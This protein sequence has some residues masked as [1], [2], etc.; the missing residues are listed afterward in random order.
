MSG[1]F[2]MFLIAIIFALFVFSGSSAAERPD[3]GVVEMPAGNTVEPLWPNGAP[4]AKGDADGDIPS[5]TV[6]LASPEK[7]T[8]AAVVIYPGGGYGALAMDHEGHQIARWLNSLGVSGFIVKYRHRNSGAGYGHPVPL[9]DAQRAIRIVRSRSQQWGIDPNRIGILGFSA[10]G[11][12]ASTAGTHFDT[13]NPDAKDPIDRVGCRPDFMILIYPVISLAESW[14]H[15]GSKKNLLGENPDPNL[16]ELLSNEK[17]V[18]PQTPPTFLIHTDEDK[19]VPVENSIYFYLALR[20]AGVP[21]EMHIYLKGQHG[22]GLGKEGTAVADWPK[23][24]A[25]WLQ[26]CGLLEKK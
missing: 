1:N 18:T 3:A 12:L 26:T 15:N 25:E 4:L 22:F 13:G 8:G 21:S 7:A 10:G 6:Y 17:Q 16:A 14:T 5:L 23:R 19:A 2:K 11:H 24:C 9:L 20:K